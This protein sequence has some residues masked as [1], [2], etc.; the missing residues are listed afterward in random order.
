MGIEL[1]RLDS[2]WSITTVEMNPRT[3]AIASGI[4]NE[5]FAGKVNCVCG[6]SQDA[7]QALH[8]ANERFDFFFHDAAHSLEAYRQDFAAAAPMLQPG[9]VLLLDDIHWEN[10]NFY[11]GG[12]RSYQGWR[13]IVN[14][15][16]VA[17][18]VEL[19]E[20]MGLALLN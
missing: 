6:T 8:A 10:E 2:P 12:A 14:Q 4:L 3:H 17:M 20:S 15:P 13:E 9:T 5:A 16:R 19:D 18:A 7:L 11:A 1:V